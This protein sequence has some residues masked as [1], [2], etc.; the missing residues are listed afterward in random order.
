LQKNKQSTPINLAS[1][2]KSPDFYPRAGNRDAYTPTGEPPTLQRAETERKKER[3]GR[4]EGGG[5]TWIP[6]ARGLPLLPLSIRASC[7]CSAA[8]DLRSAN[9]SRRPPASPRLPTSYCCSVTSDL[10][11]LC[12]ASCCSVTSDLLLLPRGI[13]SLFLPFFALPSPRS[14]PSGPLLCPSNPYSARPVPVVRPLLGEGG[15]SGKGAAAK[16]LRRKGRICFSVP[17]RPAS[18]FPFKAWCPCGS[19]LCLTFSYFID[20]CGCAF[21]ICASVLIIVSAMLLLVY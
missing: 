15:S 21:V 20:L 9:L 18:V 14:V 3:R 10:L 8:S 13:S 5:G 2:R 16:R 17:R 11:L 12:S 7:C 4:E 1:D 6:A 19:V